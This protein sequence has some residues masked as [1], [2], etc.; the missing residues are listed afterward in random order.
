MRTLVLLLLLCSSAQANEYEVLVER[1]IDVDTVYG[2]VLFDWGV[3]W[4]GRIRSNF[5]GWESNGIRFGLANTSPEE[6]RKG[7]VA[8]EAL[9]GLLRGSKLYITPPAGKSRIG[10]YGRPGGSWRVV[11]EAGKSI[12]VKQWMKVRGHLRK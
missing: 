5:D 12:Q 9:R 8:T 7:K 2:T 1:A 11:T 4:R 10:L 3:A 6:I